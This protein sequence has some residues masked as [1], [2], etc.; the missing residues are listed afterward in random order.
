[1][2]KM[3]NLGMV[4]KFEVLRTLKKPTFWLIALGFPVMIGL[5]FGIVIWSN[6]ATKE[7]ADKLQE[8]KFSITMTDHS[9]LIKPEVAAVMKVQ[10]VDSEA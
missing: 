7:A 4:F 6:Q 8:Q 9:K 1:M 2:S 5:I 3:H 10:S